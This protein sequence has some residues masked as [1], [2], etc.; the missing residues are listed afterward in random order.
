MISIDNDYKEAMKE[1]RNLSVVERIV[2]NNG[3]TIVDIPINNMLGYSISGATSENSF[4]LGKAIM[5]QHSISINNAGHA[6]D[7]IEFEGKLINAYTGLQGRTAIRKGTF[8]INK[9]EESGD[10]I[11]IEAY[12]F[13]IYFDTPN[14]GTLAYPA[15]VLD[16]VANACAECRVSYN[17]STIPL[18]NLMI[19]Q[20]P[21][22]SAT[23]RDII[24][25]VAQIMGCY[26]RIERW[27][28]LEFGFYYKDKYTETALDDT[29]H[30]ELTDLFKL[31][32]AKKDI[33]ITGVKLKCS[34]MESGEETETIYGTEGYVLEINDNPFVTCKNVN[35][36]AQHLLDKLVGFPIRTFETSIPCDFTIEEGDIVHITDKHG[37]V[38]KSVITNCVF[39]L[40]GT[41]ELSC[42]AETEMENSHGR[43]SAA[44]R[45]INR[46]NRSTEQ[47]I[48]S[49]DVETKRLADLMAQSLGIFRTE[50]KQDDGSVIYYLHDKKN[51]EE[52]N[53]IW[54]M[55][56][57]VFAVSTNGG[58][59]WNA[60]LDASGNAVVNML[61]AVGI[62]FDWARGGT[63]TL[64]GNGNGYGTLRVY[65]D[66][67]NLV[68]EIN[69]YGINVIQ[70]SLGGWK[71]TDNS[72]IRDYVT[73]DGDTYRT[74]IH[75]PT[76][77]VSYE[78]AY[79]LQIKKAG[80]DTFETLWCIDATGALYMDGT[81]DVG[82]TV[83]FAKTLA[84]YGNAT[85]SG[86]ETVFDS[87][88]DFHNALYARNENGI[89][90][91]F[92][93]WQGDG[94]WLNNITTNGTQNIYFFPT[95]DN[96]VYLGGPD[97]R[98]KDIYAYHATI[99]T[100]DRRLKKDIEGLDAMKASAFIMGL[101]P[102]SYKMIDGDS[103]RTHYGLISQDVE[104]VMDTLGMT[105][106][107]FAGF[108]KSPK[109]E[110]RKNEKNEEYVVPVEGE[111][112]YGLRYEEFIAP[113]IKMVQYQEERIRS[114]ETQVKELMEV[115]KNDG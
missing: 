38:F 96:E 95:T 66:S 62:N 86:T 112:T 55:T 35:I 52:S 113:L 109:L 49:Y 68:G 8:V 12:D 6:Y 28:S 74:Y 47:R 33:V 94:V 37:D 90:F 115:V 114:L 104:E 9:A 39:N 25:Y 24:Q 61:S 20:E 40:Y 11:N 50:E 19:Y 110:T 93:N 71:I 98:W 103:G 48:S 1:A 64:G 22:S 57:D 102:S 34:H 43:T 3:N 53:T 5:R 2:D 97:Y 54:K 26:A 82:S 16:I 13:M 58:E 18:P 17:S 107:D 60:G 105:S 65:D 4:E 56:A 111:Y 59:T 77:D 85:F 80:S 32:K 45:I 99:S 108:I 76:G 63:I 51:L 10:V 78:M 106:L 29:A 83:T 7:N 87:T 91:R 72:I 89:Q 15:T 31:K 79:A 84:V 69:R 81:L 100:S 14:K 23:Y 70:G 46:V 73:A 41:N 30:H 42:A 88:I 101:K 67:G 27:G 44:T 92:W 75:T 36:I 21:D